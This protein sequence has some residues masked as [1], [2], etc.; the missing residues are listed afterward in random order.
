M[1]TRPA[2][3]SDIADLYAGLGIATPRAGEYRLLAKQL[4]LGPAWCFRP[5]PE[6]PIAALAGIVWGL[7]G[8]VWLKTGAGS[9]RAMPGLVRAFRVVLAGQAENAPLVSWL[10][11]NNAIGKRLFRAVGF[12]DVGRRLGSIEVWEWRERD[13][14]SDRGAGRYGG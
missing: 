7:E 10:N 6:R 12:A 4:A 11:A 13:G 8:V 1:I 14:S 9:E 2:T 5:E 3:F